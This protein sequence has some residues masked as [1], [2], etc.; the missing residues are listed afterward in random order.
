MDEHEILTML[1]ESKDTDSLISLG[2]DLFSQPKNAITPNIEYAKM[3]I[4]MR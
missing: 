1:A 2:D 4:H 3:G